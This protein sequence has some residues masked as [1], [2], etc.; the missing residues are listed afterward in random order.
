MLKTLCDEIFIS[1][2]TIWYFIY[3]ISNK[4]FWTR[5][6]RFKT[7]QKSYKYFFL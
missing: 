1:D 7:K 3:V 5:S 4:F 6:I 2:V